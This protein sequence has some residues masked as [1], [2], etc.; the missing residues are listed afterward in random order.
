MRCPCPTAAAA[1]AVLSV[2]AVVR[3]AA[4]TGSTIVPAFA[5]AQEG[6]SLGQEPFGLDRTHHTQYVDQSLL[7]AVPLGA[8]LKSIAYR[9]DTQYATS[10]YWYTGTPVW[11]LRL[12]STST[13]AMA[14]SPIW[15]SRPDQGPPDPHWTLAITARPISFPTIPLSGQ[16]PEAFAITLPFDQPFVFTGPNLGIDHFT[17]DSVNNRK[18]VYYVDAVQQTSTGGTVGPIGPSSPGCPFDRNRQTAYAPD[19]GGELE[20]L[21]FGPPQVP[22]WSLLGIT[23]QRLDL[24]VIGLFGCSLYT[25]PLL[26]LPNATDSAG[27]ARLRTAVPRQPAVAGA[28]LLSQWVVTDPSVNPA[29]GLATSEG[30]QLTIGTNLSALQ[31]PMSVVVNPNSPTSSWGVPVPGRGLVF[32]LDW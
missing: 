18:R 24:S 31:I 2:F 20:A 26:V 25:Q 7:T 21:L 16:S 9:P 5:A 1:A 17:Y 28:A 23:P 27:I 13:S 15:P 12:S 6:N 3:P 32:R 30:L 11:Y 10:T 14:P 29:V 22:V 19:P 8:A 4:Q